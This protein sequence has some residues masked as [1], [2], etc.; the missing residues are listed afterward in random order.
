[1]SQPAHLSTEQIADLLVGVLPASDALAANAHLLE[2][3]ECAGRRQELEDLTAMLEAV[4]AEP[5]PIPV[6]VAD[7]L[8]AAL[9]TASAER[10]A[11]VKRLEPVGSSGTA[12]PLRW[13]MGAA[14][15]VVLVGVGV[16][17]L[18]ALPG[19]DAN[20]A[21]SA[22]GGSVPAEH[23][24]SDT[25]QFDGSD[26]AGGKADPGSQPSGGGGDPRASAVP[27]QLP[28]LSARAVR[29]AAASLAVRPAD[30]VSPTAVGCALPVAHASVTSAVRFDDERAV[31][32]IMRA[33]R[34]ATV[35]DCETGTRALFTTGY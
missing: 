19:H 33:T 21:D 22:T 4:G 11:G 5:V 34:T 8:D 32:A 9:T 28:M 26:S 25:M 3:A 23:G 16:V 29:S 20:T 10:A 1:V 30:A 6:D 31:L 15:A 27:G 14:A 24:G 17:G 13:L 18:R 12:R 2:C 35:F 7:R